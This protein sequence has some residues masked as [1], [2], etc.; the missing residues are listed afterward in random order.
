MTDLEF[1]E[2]EKGMF[3]ISTD[4][5]GD[6]NQSKGEVGDRRLAKGIRRTNITNNGKN[7]KNIVHCKG[8][9]TFEDCINQAN[10]SRVE[11]R[12]R[13]SHEPDGPQGIMSVG[14][15]QVLIDTQGTKGMPIKYLKDFKATRKKRKQKT[16]VQPK[17]RSQRQ[18]LEYYEIKPKCNGNNDIITGSDIESSSRDHESQEN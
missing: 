12:V 3:G 14:D 16:K 9:L 18:I 10:K 6:G 7:L 1:K 15:P 5:K 4:G 11:D 17:D 8:R 2:S 13:D